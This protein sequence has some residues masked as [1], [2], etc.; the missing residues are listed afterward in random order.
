MSG[1]LL[2]RRCCCCCWWWWVGADAGSTQPEAV[3]MRSC[4]AAHLSYIS[5]Q[6]K[7]NAWISL[8]VYLA[9]TSGTRLLCRFEGSGFVVPCV[10][11][12]IILVAAVLTAVFLPSVHLQRSFE[13]PAYSQIWQRLTRCAVVVRVIGDIQR[14][15]CIFC[16]RAIFPLAIHGHHHLGS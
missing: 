4:G 11:T 13:G 15:N 6:W 7:R 14:K 1:L 16:G 12:K 8:P 10:N 3:V 2:A 5:I 9:R